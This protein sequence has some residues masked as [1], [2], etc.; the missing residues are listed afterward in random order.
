MAS[1][2]GD[3][4]AEGDFLPPYHAL[5]PEEE[6]ANTTMGNRR[7]T[8]ITLR[9]IHY[10]GSCPCH[11]KEKKQPD[12]KGKRKQPTPPPANV[13]QFDD[14]NDMTRWRGHALP[15][16]IERPASPESGHSSSDSSAADD[17]RSSKARQWA[18]LTRRTSS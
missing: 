18:W 9:E 15:T 16:L 12:K 5:F 11:P 7:R 8:T 14:I 4:V 10:L 2:D 6:P 13:F 17:S 3:F 1:A